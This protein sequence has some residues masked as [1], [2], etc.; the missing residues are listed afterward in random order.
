VSY[1]NELD[2]Q[3]KEGRITYA[4][5]EDFLFTNPLPIDVEIADNL[6]NAEAE[7]MSLTTGAERLRCED[8][9]ERPKKRVRRE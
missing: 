7:V 5:L 9:E 3:G 2:A 1:L 4:V 6:A 8:V